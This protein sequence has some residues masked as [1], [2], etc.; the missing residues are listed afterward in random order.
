MQPHKFSTPDRA[1]R[2]PERKKITGRPTSSWYQLQ[3]AGLAPRPFPLGGRT[4]GWSFNELTE[5]V[6]AQKAK[7]DV[8]ARDDDSWQQLGDVAARVTQKVS[9]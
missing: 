8:A 5:W 9:G 4:V 6:E 2:E 1:V 7:R 3:D